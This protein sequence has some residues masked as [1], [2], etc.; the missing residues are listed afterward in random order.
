MV[1]GGHGCRE[2]SH[3]QKVIKE[4]DKEIRFSLKLLVT[5]DFIQEIV[6]HGPRVKVLQPE[7]LK[8]EVI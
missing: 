8:N 6:S 1:C 7:S 5:E 3:S 2:K 4:T